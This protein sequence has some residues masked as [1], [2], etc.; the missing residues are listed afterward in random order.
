MNESIRSG[1]WQKW[2][3]GVS[4]A[5]LLSII[6]YIHDSDLS[7]VDG[8]A[9][10]IRA[11]TTEIGKLKS[12]S[13]VRQVQATELEKKIEKLS[14]SVDRLTEVVIRLEEKLK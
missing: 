4:V 2:A 13:A 12:D 14:N 8:N 6:V 10:N 7:R 3:L 1:S 9:G 5:A 11:L